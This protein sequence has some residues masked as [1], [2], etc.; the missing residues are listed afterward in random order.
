MG[1]VYGIQVAALSTEVAGEQIIKDLFQH[2]AEII[3]EEG[4]YKILIADFL[5]YNSAKQYQRK[6]AIK[7]FIRELDFSNGAVAKDINDGIS[8]R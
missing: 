6:H 3:S 8:I 4:Y 7:G 1:A 5:S 2:K